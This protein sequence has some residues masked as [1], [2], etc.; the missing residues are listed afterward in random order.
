MP[1]S[2]ENSKIKKWLDDN[3]VR[4]VE[5]QVGDFAGIARGKKLPVEKFVKALGTNELRLPDSIFGMTVDCE[6]ISNN[7]ITDLEE[8]VFLIPDFA[9]VGLVPWCER[10]TAYFICDVKKANGEMLATPPRQVL[11]NVLALYAER[12]WK[13]VVAPEFEFTLLSGDID[14]ENWQTS[15]EP[16]RGR[17]GRLTH[18]KGVM[19]LDGLNE[20]GPVF[21]DVRRYCTSMGLP[22][23]GLVQEAGVGQFE[24]NVAH[25]EPLRMADHS[26]QF[27]RAMKW[28]AA[29]HDLH[30]SFMAKP[31]VDDFGNA[32][33]VHQSV[34]DADSGQNLFADEDGKDT[35][36]FHAHI[37]GLQ[38]YASASML[39]FA[40]Y[41]NSY[42]RFGSHLSSPGNT[43]WGAE[44][45][46][47]G[48]RVP[49]GGRAA[50]RIENRIAGS[51]TNPYLVIAASLLCG[52][53]GMIEGSK[54]TEPVTGSAYNLTSNT[55]PQHIHAAVAT[56]EACDVFR[57][58]LSDEF[59]STYLD[60][61]KA[62]IQARANV[63]SSWDIKY[64]L[65]NI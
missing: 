29:E 56:L 1:S 65:T 45:R 22:V 48:L 59:V 10:V 28:A 5:I 41:D 20:F 47:V 40:P 42:L 18:D 8:D 4:D 23:D 16:P 51:D 44:N 49:D 64:L 62:E 32:M 2:D 25:G 60:V 3:N 55:L 50:R 58:L 53:L 9:T 38:K 57:E 31:Y 54:P 12:N 24:F 37:A 26:V 30:V 17:S 21:D 34:V 61:K 6:F 52:Y 14:P 19:S 11:K 36:L 35:G 33:H 7:Y 43:H 27:K 46:S 39:F 13:P 15:L 63:L